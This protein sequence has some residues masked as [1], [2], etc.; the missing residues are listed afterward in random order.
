M[1]MNDPEL[2]Q[3]L[4]AMERVTAFPRRER[5]YAAAVVRIEHAEILFWSPGVASPYIKFCR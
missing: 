1:L 3:Y 4:R 5:E 2:R